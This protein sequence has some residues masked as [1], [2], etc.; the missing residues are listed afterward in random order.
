[1]IAEMSRSCSLTVEFHKHVGLQTMVHDMVAALRRTRHI[2]Y[3]TIN[4]MD[5]EPGE[6]RPTLFHYMEIN[7]P[8][9][10]SLQLEYNVCHDT[11]PDPMMGACGPATHRGYTMLHATMLSVEWCD[12][13]ENISM[14]PSVSVRLIEPVVLSL[15]GIVLLA[16]FLLFSLWAWSSG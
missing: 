15:E 11:V 10:R 13:L 3:L 6:I 8:V 9:I 2:Q 16:C 1:M 14:F 12:F 5:Y 4:L 7:L